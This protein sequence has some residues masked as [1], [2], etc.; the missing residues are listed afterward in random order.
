M[1][2]Q[3]EFDFGPEFTSRPLN[4]LNPGHALELMDRLHVM[5]DTLS[6]HA[7]QHPLAENYEE[8]RN[9]I[10]VAIDKLWDAY[11][12]VGNIEYTSGFLAGSPINYSFP[13]TNLNK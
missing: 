11:Q 12:L 4:E 7:A 8:V 5:M 6:I 10:L 9:L 2:T 13:V 3:L 1:T